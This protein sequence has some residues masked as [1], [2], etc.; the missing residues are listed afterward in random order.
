M[1]RRGKGGEAE[2]PET[3]F[4]MV[5][6]QKRPGLGH[7]E[8]TCSEIVEQPH[9]GIVPGNQHMLSIVDRLSGHRIGER[10]GAAS[11]VRFLFEQED[12]N[13]AAG[14]PDASGKAAQA[15]ADDDDGIHLE[16]PENSGWLSTLHDRAN[17]EYFSRWLSQ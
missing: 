2:S 4:R 13:S 5:Q 15:S 6:N 3:F 14:K 10:I 12:G 11:G 16:F 7:K 8:M 17:Q 9:R 1:E